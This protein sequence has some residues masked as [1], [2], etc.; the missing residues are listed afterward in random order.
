MK[1]KAEAIY[2][3]LLRFGIMELY[4]IEITKHILRAIYG[5]AEVIEMEEKD[6]VYVKKEVYD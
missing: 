1:N 4:A 5:G 3:V 6:G 2:Q